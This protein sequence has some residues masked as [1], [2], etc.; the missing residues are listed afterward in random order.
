MLAS[1]SLLPRAPAALPVLRSAAEI[2]TQSSCWPSEPVRW[3][4]RTGRWCFVPRVVPDVDR[5]REQQLGCTFERIETTLQTAGL[6]VTDIVRTWFVLEDILSWYG[7]FNEMRTAFF[8]ERGVFEHLLP[9]STGVGGANAWG[10]AVVAGVLAV[11]PEQGR[12]HASTVR[13]PLQCDA[14][15]YSSSFSRA[16]RLEWPGSRRLY[17][18][19]TASIAPGGRSLHEGDVQAQIQETFDVIDQLL[20]SAHLD[21]ADIIE[22]KAYFRR[23]DDVRHLPLLRRR[24]LAG[25]LACARAD[26]CRDELLFELELVAGQGL[27]PGE[28]A[29]P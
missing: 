24:G 4:D 23:A 26:I 2:V 22:S 28:G 25:R 17:V 19:G 14:M 5:C 27:G 13:S 1:H 8:R 18:S 9:A 21:K 3:H 15:D 16:V 6:A 12:L 10:A 29:L 7:A 20:A 11:R